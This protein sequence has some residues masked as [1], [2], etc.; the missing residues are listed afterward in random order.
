RM[1]SIARA[2]AGEARTRR[3][4][5]SS[6]GTE[7]SCRKSLAFCCARSSPTA[8]AAGRKAPSST[9]CNRWWWAMP[10]MFSPSR[11]GSAEIRIVTH[12]DVTDGD[13]PVAALHEVVDT[14][15]VPPPQ[16]PEASTLEAG[17]RPPLMLEQL[18]R[19]ALATGRHR[20]HLAEGADIVDPVDGLRHVPGAQRGLGPDQQHL[21]SF[22]DGDVRGQ[23]L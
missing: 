7:I 14:V 15:L 11:N 4:I 13:A 2:T 22:G 5:A 17:L 10:I 8:T 12:L 20:R 23:G 6:S 18:P 3:A 21:R 9:A 16:V 1:Y 19:V